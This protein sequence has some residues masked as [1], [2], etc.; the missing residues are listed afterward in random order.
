MQ[1]RDEEIAEALKGVMQQWQAKLGFYCSIAFVSE[2]E[3]EEK[4]AQGD[5]TLA[6][7]KLNGEYNRPEAYLGMFTGNTLKY[8]AMGDS[9]AELIAQASSARDE[10]EEYELCKQAEKMLVSDGRFLPLA[11]V[12]EYFI[13]AKNCENINYDAF[14]GQI[15]YRNA[16]YFGD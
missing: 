14:T 13:S 4:L 15:D 8:S 12:T 10:N 1:G 6:L 7:T 16:L 5:Y 9:Y 3:Y 11:Y 2:D